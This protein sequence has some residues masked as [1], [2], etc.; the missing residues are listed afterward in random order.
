MND[1]GGPSVSAALR[2]PSASP[3]WAKGLND[4]IRKVRLSLPGD[5]PYL[6][7]FICWRVGDQRIRDFAIA[8]F[9]IHEAAD[10]GRA[11]ARHIGRNYAFGVI[12]Y[13][14]NTESMLR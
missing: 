5:Q 13:A 14:S 8:A 6:R 12:R 3:S 2:V 7:I 11:H 1:N 4:I 10:R 9:T